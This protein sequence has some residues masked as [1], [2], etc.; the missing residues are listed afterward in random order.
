MKDYLALL[1]VIIGIAVINAIFWGQSGYTHGYCQGVCGPKYHIN[2]RVCYCEDQ[3]GE[4]VKKQ[5][6]P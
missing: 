5:P 4:V 3:A 6:I 2:L 1:L